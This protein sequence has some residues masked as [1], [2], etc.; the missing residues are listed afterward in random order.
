[1]SSEHRSTTRTQPDPNVVMTV[2]GE[3]N[4][5]KGHAQHSFQLTSDWKRIAD[6]QPLELAPGKYTTRLRLVPPPGNDRRRLVTSPPVEFRVLESA[7][8]AAR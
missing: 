7:D 5:Y 8:D 4:A 3:W 6:A 2:C 1:M